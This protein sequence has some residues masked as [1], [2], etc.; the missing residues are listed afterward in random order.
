MNFETKIE[1]AKVSVEFDFQPEE[2]M[3]RYYSDGTGYPGCA[4]SVDNVGVY[5]QTRKFNSE[6]REFEN[7]EIDV[8]D[9]LVELGYDIEQMCWDYLSELS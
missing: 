8:T 1:E 7:V 9:F 2:P 4:A 3:V 6:K 5:W